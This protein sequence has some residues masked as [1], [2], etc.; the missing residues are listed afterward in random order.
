MQLWWSIRNAWIKCII[1]MVCILPISAAAQGRIDCSIFNSHILH[2]D[3]RYCVMLPPNYQTDTKTKYPILYFLH[4]LGENEQTLLQSGGW[5]LIE[6][7]RR[8][9]KVGDFLMVAPEGRGSFFIN[10]AGGHD[11]YSDFFLAEFLPFIETKYRVIRERK[12]RGVTGLSMGGYGALRFAFA[13]PELFGSVSAQSPALMTESPRELNADLR[14]AGP[15]AKLLGNVF[16]N[17]I[18][19]AHWNQHNPFLLARKNQ[20]QIRTQ[21][22]YINCGQQDEYGFAASAEQMHKQLV[23]EKIPHQFQLYRGGHNAEYFLS[24]L[25]ETIEFHWHAFPEVRQKR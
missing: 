22:I 23:A 24:H 9:H 13:H 8:D 2:R 5:D 21:S 12:S 19:V 15:L 1:A 25:G 14:D 7:L 6:D 10:S 17:P 20:A 11:R 18:N 16:G 4:G 3:V